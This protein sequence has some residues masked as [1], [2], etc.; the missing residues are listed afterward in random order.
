MLVLLGTVLQEENA[1][2]LLSGWK[3]GAPVLPEAGPSLWQKKA[4]AAAVLSAS[5]RAW[6]DLGLPEG[7]MRVIAAAAVLVGTVSASEVVDLTDD[8]FDAFIAEHET[9]MVR[10]ARAGPWRC[11]GGV[12]R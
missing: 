9:T 3:V 12:D 1:G 7:E 2:K 8:G 10:A 5:G 4:A 6:L 11:E